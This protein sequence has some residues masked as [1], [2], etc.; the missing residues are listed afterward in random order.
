LKTRGIYARHITRIYS[1]DDVFANPLEEFPRSPDKPAT[2][3]QGSKTHRLR[4]S[5]I[6]VVYVF[7]ERPTCE[8]PKE[9]P[10]GSGESTKAVTVKF[11][12]VSVQATES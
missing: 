8:D 9:D 6:Y 5:G 1:T 7:M 3:F 2:P 4:T 11:L 12:L 10:R